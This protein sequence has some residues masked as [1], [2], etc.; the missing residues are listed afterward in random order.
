[1]DDFDESVHITNASVQQKYRDNKGTDLPILWTLNQL[2]EYYDSIGKGNEWE[3][4]IYPVIK[5][6]IASIVEASVHSIDLVPGRFELF[7]NDWIITEDFKPYLL[8]VNRCPGLNYYSPV[9]KI[10]CGTIMEDLIKGIHTH[11][12]IW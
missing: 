11:I 12:Y 8:E 4:K 3:E 6:T 9:S 2:I 10:V 7:G 5:N 1:M